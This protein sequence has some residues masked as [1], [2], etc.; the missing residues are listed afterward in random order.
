MKYQVTKSTT[1]NAPIDKVRPLIEN[2]QNWD[3]WSP[4][5]IV[6]PECPTEVTGS[7]GEVGHKMSWDGEIIGS[8]SNTLNSI[9]SDSISYDLA[10]LKPFKSK[11]KVSFQIAEQN[12]QTK[13]TWT[14][15]SSMP[16]FLFFMVKTMKNWIGMDYDRGLRMLKEI[17]ENGEVKAS[18]TNKGI[19]D[20]EG[21]SYVGI[22]RSCHFSE[23]PKL[24]S[25]DF[26]RLVNDVV[27]ERKK[28]ARHWVCL[29]PKFD[30]SSM[31]V[32]YIAAI[33]DEDL[34]GENL[35]SDYETGKIAD[36]KAVE[37]HHEGSYE[38]L[39][40]AWSMAMM[41]VRAKKY[42]ASGIPFEQYWNSPM[43]VKPEELKTSIFMPIKG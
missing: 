1:I 39:G 35:G 9:K 30:M 8:G 20:Y 22:R 37:I 40:N 26:E 14:M 2:F 19:Q 33:S 6:E 17:S 3:S 15:D 43:E 32:T 5:R 13:V 10:F 24:M 42:K 38:F 31:K 27:V 16:F 29:Y 28:G 4:W 12:D 18:T 23:M 36:S 11:A 41:Y 7:P 34:K 21:F 25:K